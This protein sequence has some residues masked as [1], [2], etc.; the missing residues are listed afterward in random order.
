M[1]RVDGNWWASGLTASA[2]PTSA[3]Y[4]HSVHPSLDGANPPDHND[5]V[6]SSDSG[7]EARAEPLS[8]VFDRLPLGRII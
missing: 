4:G 6:I 8:S 3:A 2:H 1:G 5:T 7:G